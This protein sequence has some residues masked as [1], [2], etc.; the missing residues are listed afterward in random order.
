MRLSAAMGLVKKW[1]ASSP[2]G[3]RISRPAAPLNL[4]MSIA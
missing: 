1:V 2:F 4:T 3:G